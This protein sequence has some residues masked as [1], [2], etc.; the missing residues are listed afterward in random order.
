MRVPNQNLRGQEIPEVS[1]WQGV[2]H[3]DTVAHPDT[4]SRQRQD[5]EVLTV[6]AELQTPHRGNQGI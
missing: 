3:S 6:P 4:Q 1:L 5:Y 2:R